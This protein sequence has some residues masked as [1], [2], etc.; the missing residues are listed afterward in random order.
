[1][2]GIFFAVVGKSGVGK[3]TLLDLAKTELAGSEIYYF[4]TRTITRPAKSRGE[5]HISI[6]VDEFIKKTSENEFCLWWKAHGF[7]YGLTNEINERLRSGCNVVAN[8]SR[9]SVVEASQKFARIEVIEITAHTE[10][11]RRR[12][13]GRGRESEDEVQAR[14]VR[15]VDP[16]WRGS[17]KTSKIP[18][19]GSPADAARKLVEKLLSAAGHTIEQV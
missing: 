9:H 18:N 1:M 10:N 5:K 7:Y 15:E 14:Q 4:P 12:L 8:I 17:L 11:V 6:S 16:E 13:L 3:D 2:A 19:D